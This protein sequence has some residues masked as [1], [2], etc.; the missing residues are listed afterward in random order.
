MLKPV[1]YNERQHI[2]YRAGRAMPEESRRIWAE[3]LARRA[4]ERRPLNV[5]DL[6]SGTGRM[7]PMLAKT[8]GGQVWGVEP[9]DRMRAQAEADP[10]PA[11]A[12][13]LEGRAEAI[14][15]AVGA[16]DLVVM[17]LSLHHVA[18][19][20]AAARE[21]RRVLAPGGRVLVR[22]QF[23]D[24]MQPVNWHVWFDGAHEAELK[25]FPTTAEVEVMFAAVGLER[26][27]LDVVRE[28]YADTLADQAARLKTRSISTFEH[29]DEAAIEAGFR[30]LDEAVARDPDGGPIYGDGD[31]MT[32][33]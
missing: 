7:T 11:N 4:P 27:A 6:G 2:G 32:F 31:L 5:L 21:I 9:H 19:R 20:A 15:L 23:S 26:L 28:R 33:G 18:D 12:A 17:F 1:D 30:K 24:R 22:S 8:F 29:L 25:M 13:Y 3:A 10:H 14:P 16:C